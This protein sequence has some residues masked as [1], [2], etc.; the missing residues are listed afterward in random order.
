MKGNRNMK[1]R[2][3]WVA[4]LASAALTTEAQ[5][6]GHHGG[7]AHFAA[8]ARGGFAPA[9]HGAP[10][11]NFGGGRFTAP[12]PRFSSNRTPMAFREQR[13]GGSS[14]AF[15]RSQFETARANHRIDATRTVA[16][17]ASRFPRNRQAPGSRFENRGAN[18]AGNHVFARRTANWHRDWDRHRDHFWNGHRC[19][20]VN[21][22]WFI[23]D[24]GFY[25]YDYWY[26][27]DYYASDY[28]AEP[29][30][31]DSGY[32]DSDSSVAAEQERLAREGYY[33]GE[34]DG[35]LGPETRRAI[36][37]Y[38]SDHGQRVTGY[39]AN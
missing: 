19:R 35:I 23:Y 27:S 3:Y 1:I 16:G 22:A 2:F 8:P 5:A 12:G 21:G 31:Y 15:A 9:F 37:R 38:Q 6:G 36:A 30:A 32:G 33:R 20:F 18:A 17:N 7:G 4:I 25:P 14:R 13:F 11:S 29:Y 10:R 28:Y 24:T 39:L 26:P 34:I